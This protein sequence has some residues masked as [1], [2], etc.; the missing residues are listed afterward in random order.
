MLRDKFNWSFF[1]E[2]NADID[3]IIETVQPE[4]DLVNQKYIDGFRNVFPELA[5]NEGIEDWEG[6]LKIVANTVIEDWDF[7]RERVINRIQLNVPF[8]ETYLKRLLDKIIGEGLWDY[9]LDFRNYKIS[10][11]GFL[12]IILWKDELILILSIILPA[13]LVPILNFSKLFEDDI[14]IG[15]AKNPPRAATFYPETI[16]GEVLEYR[17]TVSM[18]AAG[19]YYSR[20]EA[21]VSVPTQEHSA[22]GAVKVGAAGSQYSRIETETN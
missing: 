19:S 11:E 20:I 17:S 1:D 3:A 14:F 8:T 21:V 6:L 16:T 18:G 13:N 10:I 22:Q 2:N 9:N 5:T 15:W 4:L 12:P 7:R